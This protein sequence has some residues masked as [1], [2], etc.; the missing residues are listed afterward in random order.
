MAAHPKIST[1]AMGGHSLGGVVAADFAASHADAVQGVVFWAS[2]PRDARLI[3]TNVQVLSISG[4]LDGLATP[5]KIDA[6]RA[7]LPADARFEVIAGGNHAQFGAYGNQRGDNP[8]KISA[9]DQAAQTAALT[10]AF[11]AS[12]A[13]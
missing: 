11:L 7:N 4:S 5:P 12:L 13:P 1:W 6:S 9:D 2:Y 8:A 3:G 10:A